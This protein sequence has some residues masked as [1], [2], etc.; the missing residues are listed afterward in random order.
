MKFNT[1][2]FFAIITFISIGCSKNNQI[3]SSVDGKDLVMM[4]ASKVLVADKKW[5][6]D[7][8]PNYG[9]NC[10]GPV[11]IDSSK[12][13]LMEKLILAIN[14][15]SV[16]QF[17]SEPNGDYYNLISLE[18]NKLEDLRNGTITAR[19]VILGNNTYL[20]YFIQSKDTNQGANW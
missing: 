11:Y 18:N 19:V 4:K 13:K 7:L 20:T 6:H 12:T 15:N 10:T 8:C 5:N 3:P 9:G 2:F 1:L 17:F 14:N 16:P